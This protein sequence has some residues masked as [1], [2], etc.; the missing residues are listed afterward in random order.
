MK[1]LHCLVAIGILLSTM[2][3]AQRCPNPKLQAA[4]I[5]GDTINAYVSLQQGPLKAAQVRLLSNGKTTWVGSTDD[6]GS[7]QIKGLRPGT[8]SL[9]VKGWGSA[10][11]RISPS[12][13]HSFGNGEMLDYSLMLKDNG[14]VWTVKVAN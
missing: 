3:D 13:T 12:L 2:C 9:I 8:Y 11:I 7:F 14:C 4:A 1:A 10:T 6:V 5:G